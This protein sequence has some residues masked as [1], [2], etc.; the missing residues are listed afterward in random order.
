M[1][2]L[3]VLMLGLWVWRFDKAHRVS[4]AGEMGRKRGASPLPPCRNP[5]PRR[6]P[7]PALYREG[8][9]RHAPITRTEENS[10][11]LTLSG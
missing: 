11:P 5:Q 9:R 2:L 4:E 8:S 1:N 7:G 3:V 6:F 10:K